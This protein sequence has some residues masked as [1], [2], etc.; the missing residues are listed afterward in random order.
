MNHSEHPRSRFDSEAVSAK[1]I[2]L[3]DE[4][5]AR[6]EAEDAYYRM[7][8]RVV[9][10]EKLIYESLTDVTDLKMIPVPVESNE[11]EPIIKC[12]DNIADPAEAIEVEQQETVEVL[13]VVETV[14]RKYVPELLFGS[15]DDINFVLI[16]EPRTTHF[17]LINTDTV[18][19]DLREISPERALVPFDISNRGVVPYGYEFPVEKVGLLKRIKN[20]PEAGRK[21]MIRNVLVAEIIA[22]M[23]MT[24]GVYNVLQVNAAVDKSNE[25]ADKSATAFV[26]NTAPIVDNGSDVLGVRAEKAIIEAKIEK[27]RTAAANLEYIPEEASSDIEATETYKLV[28]DAYRWNGSILSKSAGTVTGPNG[29]ETYYNLNMSGI[30]SMMRGRGNTDTYWVRSDG[31]KMLGNYVMVAAN[32]NV[33]PRGSIVKS[34][35]GLAIVCDTGGF[36]A[37]NPQQLDIA[38]AW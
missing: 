31:C 10:F 22:V 19:A 35:R 27:L 23:V 14:E 30:V 9:P 37:G 6:E 17:R 4:T 25:I 18:G 13:E 5:I 12:S 11:F 24:A 20:M 28:Q 8:V 29:R 36:A 38:T 34:S 3:A 7:I 16:G 32:L 2:K 15:E 26:T 33:H 21:K 1:H